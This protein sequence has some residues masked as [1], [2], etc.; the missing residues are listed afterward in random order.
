MAADL[1]FLLIVFY[2]AV[3]G[4]R[5]G[6]FKEVV[7]V[8]ALVVGIAVARLLRVPAGAAVAAKSGLPVLLAEVAA[9]IAV[10]VV[11]FLAVA[12]AGRLVLKKLRGK[13]ADDRL[14]D[15]AE[16]IADAIGGDTT[17]GPVTRFTDPLATKNGVFYWSDKLLG[18]LLGVCKGIVTGWILFG[19][20]LWA[21][22]LGW[23]SS[24]ARSI[25]SS[26][27]AAAFVEHMDPLLRASPEYQLA[28]KV[29][30]MRAIAEVVK[31]DAARFERL[32]QHPE[33]SALSRDPKVQALAQDPEVA[34]AWSRRDVPAL[35]RN[36]KV[37]ELLKDPDVRAKVAAV[38]W[39]RVRDAVNGPVAPPEPR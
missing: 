25:E 9:V 37:Q 2:S 31:T 21:D 22:R 8:A 7:Q 16:G 29:T 17:K 36:P 3:F 35:L 18:L 24:F 14:D 33:M 5:R 6:L 4:A 10:W 26:H 34:A 30:A 23:P 39:E 13:G 11:T 38:D 15:K 20:V 27:A 1:V 28:T 32:K 12:I 19:F